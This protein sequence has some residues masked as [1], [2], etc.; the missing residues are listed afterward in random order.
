MSELIKEMAENAK[1]KLI[2]KATLLDD[3]FVTVLPAD[4]TVKLPIDKFFIVVNEFVP[5]YI[6][7]DRNT[8]TAIFLS[9][10]TDT[11]KL[12]LLLLLAKHLSRKE[13]EKAVKLELR[14][15]EVEFWID[16]LTDNRAV[17]CFKKMY[18]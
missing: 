14:R 3:A 6:E 10:Y 7:T 8:Y 5:F 2:V 1:D 17:K 11:R 13:L 9:E 12:L 16:K 4:V 15:E 18:L